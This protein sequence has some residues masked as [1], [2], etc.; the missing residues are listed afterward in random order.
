MDDY[1]FTRQHRT[2]NVHGYALN[3]S[4]NGGDAIVGSAEAAAANQFQMDDT[5]RP[6]KAQRKAEKRK[7]QGKGDASIVD[8]TGSY[9]G[10]WAEYEGD[11][12]PEDEEE[13][14]ED[15]EEWRAEKRRREEAKAAAQEKNKIARE[16]KSIFHGKE[17]TDYAGR[18]Y[19]HIPT[20]V[21]VKLNPA[22]GA[23]PPTSFIPE[24][25]IHTWTGH[26]KGI[27]AIRLFPKSGHLLLSG[28]MDTKIKVSWLHGMGN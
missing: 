10:P 14:E 22:E 23:P 18:T 28:S 9:K 4:M 17:L 20:D 6:T 2:F 1:E 5:V 19:M 7:R 8:G 21:D 11:K 13:N 26:N 25:C 27:S 12:V 3:P 15:D 24:R 16:E